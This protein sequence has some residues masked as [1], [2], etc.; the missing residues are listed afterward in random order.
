MRRRREDSGRSSEEKGTAYQPGDV[1]WHQGRADVRPVIVRSGVV[2]YRRG[3]VAIGL[4]GPGQVA[5]PVPGVDLPV[6]ATTDLVAVTESVVETIDPTSRP[7]TDQERLATS[8]VVVE[9]ADRLGNM[10]LPQRLAAVL[11]QITQFQGSPVVGCRQDILAMAASARRETVATIL[12]AWRDEDWIQTR[13]R[14]CKVI[15]PDALLRI[16]DRAAGDEPVL[17]S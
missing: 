4:I 3:S 6:P 14:R 8:T 11:L 9:A 10:T 15:D 2:A 5:L 13:Y 1:I 12:S 7:I 16:R 17:Y